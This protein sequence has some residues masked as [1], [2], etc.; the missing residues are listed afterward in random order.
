MGCFCERCFLGSFKAIYAALGEGKVDAGYLP[1]DSR[2]RGQNEF[3]WNALR[4]LPTG[5][6]GIVTTRRFI[7][8]DRELVAEVVRGFVDA[9]HLFKTRPDTVVPL[10]QRFLQ[11]S[12]R[13]AVEALH[14]FY[15]PLFRK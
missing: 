11:L 9:I 13:N 2:F 7:T 4:G 5:T 10:L 6:G 14:A 3:G 15:V 8:A 1:V 12:D